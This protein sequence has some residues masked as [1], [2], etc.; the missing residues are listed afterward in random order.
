MTDETMNGMM[1]TFSKSGYEESTIT[2]VHHLII[3]RSRMWPYN[4]YVVLAYVSS[5]KATI[6]YKYL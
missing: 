4:S 1:D 6:L 2:T 5:F 3:D